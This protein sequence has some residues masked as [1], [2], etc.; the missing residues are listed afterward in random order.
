M[1]KS[2]SRCGRGGDRGLL[3]YSER[4]PDIAVGGITEFAER[5]E[6]TEDCLPSASSERSAI[7]DLLQMPQ[8]IQT[9][10]QAPWPG[11]SHYCRLAISPFASSIGS[12]PPPSIIS[13]NI[14]GIGVTASVWPVRVLV[15]V[16]SSI[17][18]SARSPSSNACAHAWTF[19]CAK[20]EIDGIAEEQP[21]QRLGQQKPDA[22]IA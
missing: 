10:E 6:N 8:R 1:W 15:A 20:A 12:T 19:E 14:G 18:S 22:A 2:A 17:D 5:S 9:M 7:S 16:Q 21:V 13:S 4:A 11:F 3:G